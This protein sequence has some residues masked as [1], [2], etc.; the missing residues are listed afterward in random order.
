MAAP[1]YT[2]TIARAAELLGEDQELLCEIAL[3][4][5]PEDGCLSIHGTGDQ[6]TIA[7]TPFGM[8]SLKELIPEYK[9]RQS[10]PRS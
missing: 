3:Y 7:F 10:S 5:E 4:M 2:F 1:S 6:Q 9:R 8:E